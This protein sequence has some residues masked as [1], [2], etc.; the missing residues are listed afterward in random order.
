M[1]FAF[2]PAGLPGSGS[3]FQLQPTRE[4]DLLKKVV[5]VRPEGCRVRWR[6]LA[7]LI[8]YGGQPD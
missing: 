1:P 3:G 6:D 8:Q 4:R 2:L 5:Q 7:H